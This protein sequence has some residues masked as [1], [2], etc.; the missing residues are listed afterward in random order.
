M[1]LE[2]AVRRASGVSAGREER[3]MT[4][5]DIAGLT[6]KADRKRRPYIRTTITADTGRT[7]ITPSLGNGTNGAAV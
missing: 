5:N 6:A 3:T 7:A 2:P 1:P 4:R